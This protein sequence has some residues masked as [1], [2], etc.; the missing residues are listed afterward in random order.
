MYKSI[1]T[2][3]LGVGVIFPR[4]V[5]YSKRNAIGFGLIKPEIVIVILVMKLYI[6]NQIKKQ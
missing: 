5:I 6:G 3:K 4:A 2:K 1:V